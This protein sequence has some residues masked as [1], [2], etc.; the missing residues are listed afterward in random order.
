[1]TS[2]AVARPDPIDSLRRP[3]K[4]Y[5]AGQ[6]AAAT[7]LGS[8]IAGCLLLRSNFELFGVHEAA[9]RSVVWGLLG[10]CVSLALAMVVPENTPNAL[11]PAL[12]TLALQQIA[13]RTQGARLVSFFENGGPKHSHWRVVGIGLGCLAIA[14]VALFAVIMILPPELIE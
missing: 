8:P 11:I 3:T 2:G 13:A 7:F 14:V 9:R 1:M 4:A 6:V 5:S 10:T 12:Y